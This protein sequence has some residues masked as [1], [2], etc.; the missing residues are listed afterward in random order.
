M[1]RRR[2]VAAV[3]GTALGAPLA[4][5]AQQPRL[6]RIGVVLQGGPY[7][8][9][10][11]GLRDGLKE[12]GLAEARQ[13]VLHVRDVKSDLKSVEAAA[14]SLELEKVDLIYAIG[15]SVNIA[16]KRATKSV[17]VVF[18]A[19]S[20]PVA[21]G[22]IANFRKPGGR[23]TGIHSQFI[24]LTAKRLELLKALLP[25]LRRAI[26]FYNPGNPVGTRAMKL[27][28]DASRQLNVEFVAREVNT[29]E[30]LRK[31]LDA[32][33]SGEADAFFMVGDGLVISQTAMVID[34][35][36]TRKLPVMSVDEASVGKGALASYGVSYHVCGRLAAKYVQRILQGANPADLPIEQIDTP[37]FVVNLKAAKALGLA[38]PESVLIRAN[39]IIH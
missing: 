33:Q 5:K 8:A 35:A 25:K 19:G 7:A 23:F 24:D 13:Y 9:A 37:H 18:Y 31:G 29:V 14:R 12:L 32:L 11:E 39:R 6:Y 36:N 30:E 22:L 21:A 10:I 3:I 34:A 26:T 2:F 16:V 15:T 17:P 27:A 28:R 1:N 20:D 38:I 4:V